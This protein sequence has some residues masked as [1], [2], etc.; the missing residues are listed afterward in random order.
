M[1]FARAL[2]RARS[3]FSCSPAFLTLLLSHSHTL[4][5]FALFSSH[6]SFST[7]LHLSVSSCGSLPGYSHYMAVTVDGLVGQALH[8]TLPPACLSLLSLS[9]LH[10]THFCHYFHLCCLLPHAFITLPFQHSKSLLSCPHIWRRIVLPRRAEQS[11]V[12]RVGGAF[13]HACR[14][15]RAHA[16]ARAASMRAATRTA[17]RTCV[18][19]FVAAP[20][21]A[22]TFAARRRDAAC[23]RGGGACFKRVPRA[24]RLTRHQPLSYLLRALRNSSPVGIFGADA[25]RRGL[26]L[27]ARHSH[28]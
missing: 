9:L 13:Y 11:A 18:H 4:N 26:P 23:A 17:A 24:R 25:H 7:T 1:L 16:A 15:A 27:R 12:V 3:L 20:A 2:L 22:S 5:S 21:S 28:Y 8:C 19:V 14:R 6:L 10:C